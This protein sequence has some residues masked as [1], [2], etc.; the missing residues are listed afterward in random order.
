[1]GTTA[2]VIVTGDDAP[3]RADSAVARLHALEARWSRFI[4]DSEVSR[5]NALAALPL[6]VS[7]SGCAEI[8]L[9]PLVR[10][11]RLGPGVAF[12][13]GGIGKGLAAD[14]VVGELRAD[15]A[16]GALVNV[17]G[18][19]RVGGEAPD[20]GGWTVA[21]ADPLHPDRMLR[22]ARLASGAVASTWRTKRAWTSPDGTVAH[23]LI[24]PGT[25]RPADSGV[26]GVSVVAGLAWV[27]E[28]LAKGAFLA[29][30]DEGAAL[31]DG[32]GSAG[33][34]VDD[35]G[36]VHEAGDLARFAT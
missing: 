19:L 14:L 8:H 13:P 30:A 36:R 24:D 9:D 31:I 22:T 35:S 1:M 17:G 26:A 29:G 33:V 12:D 27:A 28:V 20:Q 3:D 7:P 18:D 16:R 23:H 6:V 5:L 11:V 21:L 2:Q 25:G 15:G 4:P 32:H 34:L 10:S